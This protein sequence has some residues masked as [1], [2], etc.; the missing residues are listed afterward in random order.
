[1]TAFDGPEVAQPNPTGTL[2]PRKRTLVSILWRCCENLAV[3]VLRISSGPTWI[4]QVFLFCIAGIIEWLLIRALLEEAAKDALQGSGQASSF[5]AIIAAFCA[6]VAVVHQFL[7]FRNLEVER[8]EEMRNRVIDECSR[9][10]KPHCPGQQS[11]ADSRDIKCSLSN[12]LA[13][14]NKGNL[15]LRCSR[16]GLTILTVFLLAAITGEVPYLLM[17]LLFSGTGEPG[18]GVPRVFDMLNIFTKSSNWAEL[19]PIQI[20]DYVSLYC[21]A[22]FF[23]ASCVLALTVVLWDLVRAAIALGESPDAKK[24]QRANWWKFFISDLLSLAM[25]YCFLAVLNLRLNQLREGKV[26]DFMSAFVPIIF[27][28]AVYALVIAARILSKVF[29]S[30]TY[31]K[32]RSEIV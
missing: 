24:D 7:I 10:N 1:M 27:L 13:A 30:E 11:N 25:W 28:T 5:V 22:V 9:N 3:G 17:L 8:E 14:S 2:R 19:T 23:T 18:E 20:R 32:I 6:A 16:Y 31:E 29:S 21:K 15:L 26:G 12:S 4:A